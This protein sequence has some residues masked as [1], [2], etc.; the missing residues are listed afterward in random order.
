MC[1][2][3]CQVVDLLQTIVKLCQC[4][5]RKIQQLTT[6]LKSDVSDFNN[7]ADD[8]HTEMS[9]IAIN[10]SRESVT[11]NADSTDCSHQDAEEIY[12]AKNSTDVI[13]SD[14]STI[15]QIKK[16]RH[17]LSIKYA[18]LDK[19]YSELK[20]ER[21]GLL[22]K[23][24]GLNAKISS[25]NTLKEDS[26][27]RLN[28]KIS[29]YKALEDTR[30]Q[31]ES[32]KKE[33]GS[34]N[35]KLQKNN[36]ELQRKNQELEH[37]KSVA[38][39]ELVRIRGDNSKKD[40]EIDKLNEKNK[41]LSA[42]LCST[43]NELK[44]IQK[45][46][47]ILPNKEKLFELAET[48]KGLPDNIRRSSYLNVFNLDD[49]VILLNQCG[50]SVR[51]TNVWSTIHKK[52]VDDGN[53]SPELTGFMLKLIDIYNMSNKGTQL[54]VIYP[55]LG[56]PYSGELYSRV[57]GSNPVKIHEVLFPGLNNSAG[58]QLTKPVVR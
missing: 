29:E 51:I 24:N 35:E 34:T 28:K 7:S 41:T 33:L 11:D 6:K 22:N 23:I 15:E 18:S 31:L 14:D 43:D 48:I 9:G 4:D 44:S 38:E 30:N 19:N 5:D 10:L 20:A 37:L 58:K 55:K 13:G 3:L 32:E 2:S 46:L 49:I 47:E 50:N 40:K 52:I 26:D 16:E 25:L 39:N 21:D 53:F 12:D 56:D 57:T 54:Q 36:N 8:V 45:R 27:D 42:E 17:D 1:K